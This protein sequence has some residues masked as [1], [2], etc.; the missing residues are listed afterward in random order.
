MEVSDIVNYDVEKGF[1]KKIT[2]V[3]IHLEDRTKNINFILKGRG[4]NN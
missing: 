2:L 1:V 4:G 3:D